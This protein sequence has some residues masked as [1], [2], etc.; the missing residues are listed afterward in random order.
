MSRLRL[1]RPIL[2]AILILVAVLAALGAGLLRVARSA[3]GSLDA[4][5]VTAAPLPAGTPSPTAPRISLP[6]VAA[7][8]SPIPPTPSASE[9][10]APVTVLLLGSDRRPGEKA[11]PRTDAII[12]ARVDPL[13]GRVALLSLPRDLWAPIPGYSSNRISNAY[14]WGERAG[15]PGAG[16]TLAR[17]TIS[18]L[19]GL[20]IDYVALIDLAGFAG[21]VDAVGGV[22][23]DVEH[24]LV[25]RRYPTVD[26]G[27]TTVRFQPGRQRLYGEA[28]LAYA[29][30]RHPDSDFARSQRQQQLLLALAERLRDRGHLANLLAAEQIAAALAGFVQTDMPREQIVALAWALRDLDLASVER[31]ALTEA[32]VRFGVGADRFAQTARPGALERL[33]AQLLGEAGP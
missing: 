11:I 30:I 27:T 13:A 21:L 10:L 29:R 5:V 8:A 16:M 31:Y 7:Q 2:V 25:D 9:P 18:D 24:E 26:Y 23:V 12:L 33:A 17:A 19:L 22:I 14:L 1:P 20:Q 3:T 6:T 15:P 4:M 28:A 32:D